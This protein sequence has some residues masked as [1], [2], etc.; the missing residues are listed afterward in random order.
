MRLSHA[1]RPGVPT[2][3]RWAPRTSTRTRRG[4]VAAPPR[5]G[6]GS[7][8]PSGAG[9]RG[10]RPGY[11]TGRQRRPQRRPLRADRRGRAGRPALGGLVQRRLRRPAR[12]RGRPPRQTGG[13]RCGEPERGVGGGVRRPRAVCA[14]VAGLRSARRCGAPDRGGRGMAVQPEAEGDGAVLAPVRD[15]IRQP[16]RGRHPEPARPSLARVVGRDGRST[17]RHRGPSGRRTPGHRRR[18]GDRSTRPAAPAGRHWHPAAAAGP[19]GG[20][21]GGTGTGT[22][23]AGRAPGERPRSPRRPWQRSRVSHSAGTGA[24]RRSP[25]RSPSRRRIWHCSWCGVPPLRDR[26]PTRATRRP[27]PPA[28]R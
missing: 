17:A 23:V 10:D 9:G 21:I 3:A 25:G 20:G 28:R 12:R 19:A 7:V 27:Y 14:A 8:L 26:A 13:R 24:R 11:R 2:I 5:G 6:A 16:A 22:C 1:V 4:R 15:R 18:S